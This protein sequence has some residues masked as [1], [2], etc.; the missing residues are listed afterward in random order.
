[1]SCILGTPTS[2]DHRVF[3][4]LMYNIVND[5]FFFPENIIVLRSRFQTHSMSTC[6]VSTNFIVYSLC[7]YKFL[8][9][10]L[11]NGLILQVSGPVIG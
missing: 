10:S 6:Q 1:M 9:S 5:T 4:K 2:R 7:S 3:L 11:W 8:Y